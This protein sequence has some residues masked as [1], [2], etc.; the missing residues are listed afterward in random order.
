MIERLKDLSF[1]VVL[2]Y[3]LAW[4]SFWLQSPFLLKF[5]SENLIVVLVALTAINTTT[6]SVVMTKLREISDRNGVDFSRSVRALRNSV[7]E[8]IWHLMIAL[9]LSILYGSA[10]LKGLVPFPDVT[11]GGLLSAVF[12]ASMDNLY[13]TSQSIFVLLRH[14]VSKS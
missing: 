13:D 11:I 7:L 5:L 10:R 1:Y 6:S 12:V 4:A 8:Q 9:A 2:G 3:G 14:E